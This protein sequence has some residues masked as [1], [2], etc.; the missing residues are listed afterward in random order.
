ML[1]D[2]LAKPARV[3]AF[4]RVSG[5]DLDAGKNEQ[6]ADR[7]ARLNE[8]LARLDA[9]ALA[10]GWPKPI[11]F[12]EIESGGEKYDQDTD[13][14]SLDDFLARPR[15]VHR[16]EQRRLL[17]MLRPGDLVLVVK[18]DRWSRD[19]RFDAD[20]EDYI[21]HRGAT[22]HSMSEP[23][24][25]AAPR[26]VKGT[27]RLQ[28]EQ[29]RDIVRE[30]MV[31]ARKRQRD[32]GE[33]TEG[34]PPFGYRRAE[35]IGAKLRDR[36]LHASAHAPLVAQ[37]FE[38]CVRGESIERICEWLR[39]QGVPGRGGRPRRWF[40][41]DVGAMLRSRVYLGEIRNSKGEWIHAHEALVDAHTWA[42]AQKALDARRLGGAGRRA[43]ESATAR[44]ADWLLRG[45]AVCARCGRRMGSV[46]AGG[47]RTPKGR[48]EYGRNYYGCNGRLS[49]DGCTAP[50]VRVDVAD[51][52]ASGLVLEYLRSH[53]AHLV[54]MRSRPVAGVDFAAARKRLLAR[55]ARVLD[56]F[57]AGD[58]TAVER[59][60]RIEKIAAELA[61][62]DA[63]EATAHALTAARDP[64]RRA[65]LLAELGALE[66]A[67]ARMAAP[68]QRWALQRLA[69]SIELDGALEKPVRV[70]WFTPEELML[71]R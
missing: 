44:N 7:V 61:A 25:W 34:L 51:A 5:N 66:R 10:M 49:G 67:W 43:G 9:Y 14:L 6:H 45:L 58:I 4:A 16:K 40:K 22:W 26:I 65:N 27:V 21:R 12:K 69:A 46:Y 33:Y 1:S 18:D 17:S 42:L 47:E 55:R 50:Y 38:R 35:R 54:A 52:H 24:L 3:L 62:L 57:E 11:H 59:K 2:S 28:K 23:W 29:Y 20:A 71:R 32:A 60:Q 15:G 53:R 48:R 8:Q 19:Q 68:E 36:F 30:N 64:K 13:G 63:Q 41:K 70:A 39:T 37:A 31:G 56:M